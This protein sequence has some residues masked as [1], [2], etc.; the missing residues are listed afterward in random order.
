MGY[1][2][3]G[4]LLGSW[5]GRDGQGAQVWTNYWFSPKSRL[6]INFRHQKVSQQF[7][8]GGESLTD[9]GAR[10]DFW[11]R[12]GVAISSSLQCERW[13][14]PAIQP[15]AQRNITASLELRIQPQKIYRPF[16]HAVTGIARTP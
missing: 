7:L 3:E 10:G 1:T 2:N 13:L 8:P 12:N 4:N 11:F 15:G 9:F 16:L 6:Q 14:F 5:I